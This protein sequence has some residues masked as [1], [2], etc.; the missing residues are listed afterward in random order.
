MIN[1]SK[2][3]NVVK[4]D[5]KASEVTKNDNDN[6]VRAWLDIKESKPYG[7]EIAHKSKYVSDLTNK[8]LSW[9]IPSIVDPFV[10]T[11]DMIN[12]SPFTYADRAISEQD[13]KVLSHFLIQR[14]DHYAFM[15]DLVTTAAEQGT[16]FV[17]TGWMF[18]EEEREVEVPVTAIDPISGQP[19][20]VGTELQKQMVTVENKPTR[21]ICDLLDIRMDPTCR[22]K[23]EDASF[24]IHDFETD[25]SS[26]RKDGRY[27]NLDKLL[28]QLQR[29]DTYNQRTYNDDTFRFEDEPR[30]K[31]I[32]HEYWGNYDLN[33]DG[34]A[35][36]VVIAWV[37]DVIIREE[38]NPLPGK[39]KPF[40]KAVYTRKP[41]QIYGEPLA[42]LTAKNQHIDSVLNRGI[43]DDLK[44]ANNGQTGTKKGFT[45][46][47]NLRRMKKGEDYEYNT[48]MNDVVY[49]QYR[50]INQTVFQVLSQ[51]AQSAE[52]ITGVMAFN[53]SNGGNPLGE[54]ATAAGASITSSAKREMHIIRGIADDC[55]IPMLRKWTRYIKEFME[56]EEIQRITDKPFVQAQND[57]EYDIKIHLE[58]KETRAAKAQQTGFVMQTMGPNMPQEQ[59]QILLARYMKLVG[60][61]DI[62]KAIEDFKPQPDPIA[63]KAKELELAK[64]EAQVFNEQAKGRE[65]AV[66]VELK[67]AKTAVE[68][69]KARTVNSDSDIKDL[70]FLEKEQGIPHQREMEKESIK[71]EKELTKQSMANDARLQGVRNK[72]GA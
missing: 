41:N 50:G 27:K 68:M 42:A 71:A 65:N 61:P 14:S 23:I 15:T 55:L 46:D 8:L 60:E 24:I 34:I 63:E 20:V 44:L 13:E 54:S 53:S 16:C 4:A 21:E 37:G 58:S 52:S 30:K 33:E 49:S 18:R 72:V 51:N 19:V 31:I 36:P 47:I 28:N 48:N 10:S 35:E 57:N 70:D 32:V 25:L 29:D 12:C 59:Q 64:L 7:T 43:F 38:D 40:E 3:I 5:Y 26:L 9:Q 17:K 62:A 11:L 22:G 1:K 2:L 6:K 56:P 67:K 39:E 45:D 66:D 69:A